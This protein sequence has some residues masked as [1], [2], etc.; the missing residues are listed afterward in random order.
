MFSLLPD[1]L[2]AIVLDELQYIQYFLPCK[3]GPCNHMTLSYSFYFFSFTKPFLL[4]AHSPFTYLFHHHISSY[5]PH[6]SDAN[7]LFPHLTT[8]HSTWLDK[9]LLALCSSSTTALLQMYPRY[10]LKSALSRSHFIV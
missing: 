3:T 2:T 5:V 10:Q 6:Y 7:L 4:L 9:T 1:S 8:K